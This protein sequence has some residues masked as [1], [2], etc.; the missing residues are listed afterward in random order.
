MR[1]VSLVNQ[2]TQGSVTDL[3]KIARQRVLHGTHI[4]V[5]VCIRSKYKHVHK[6]YVDS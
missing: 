3:L 1:P 4:H 2:L 6:E 5:Y